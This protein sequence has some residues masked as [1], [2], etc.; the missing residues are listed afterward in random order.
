M[1][2]AR[3]LALIIAVSAEVGIDPYL[4]QSLVLQENPGLVPYL[5]AGPNNNGTYD[6]GLTGLNSAYLEHFVERYWNKPW[7]FDWRE[8]YDN[9]YVG[10]SHLCYLT[11]LPK[12][13]TWLALI[14]YNAG[15]KWYIDGNTPPDSSI[16]YACKVFERWNRYRGYK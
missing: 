16:E 1:T 3:I 11:K 14:F 8:P 10:L 13:T 6:L 7:I 15:R 5:V 4:G 2:S 9:L 12:T